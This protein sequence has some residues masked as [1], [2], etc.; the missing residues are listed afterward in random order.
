MGVLNLQSY[1]NMIQIGFTCAV[2]LQHLI[3]NK[4]T[5]S[6]TSATNSQSKITI[7]N[8]PKLPTMKLNLL[9]VFLLGV[10]V[11]ATGM[12]GFTPIKGDERRLSPS[13]SSSKSSSKSSEDKNTVARV[14]AT[15]DDE[16]INCFGDF[17]K[18]N[19]FYNKCVNDATHR[20]RAFRLLDDNS[21]SGSKSKS[22]SRRVR[23][24]TTSSSSSSSDD[25]NADMY[26]Y[27]ITKSDL[28]NNC[29]GDI[30]RIA[31]YLGSE[32]S[33]SSKSRRQ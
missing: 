25:D 13:N 8:K 18:C 20:G 12:R 21:S 6:S 1:T 24:L 26:M 3:K 11:S 9:I 22:N 2:Y 32:S 27:K 23:R 29:E 10:S 31:Y 16:V 33:S 28:N 19:R 15:E 17:D 4:T 7:T 14:I 30:S 5:A